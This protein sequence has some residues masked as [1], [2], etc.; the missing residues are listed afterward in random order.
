MKQPIA[1][2]TPKLTV[3]VPVRDRR[4]LIGRALRSI[5]SQKGVEFRI[6]VVDNGSTD[7]TAGEL[8]R[9]R[10]ELSASGTDITVTEEPQAGACRARNAGFA[11]TD[12]PWVMF[13]D[14]DDEMLPGHLARMMDAA[15]DD[16]DI[17]GAPATLLTTG[18]RRIKEL[19]FRPGMR[20]HLMHATFSTQRIAV[21][22]SLLRDAGGWNASLP[23]WNDWELGVRLL[24]RSPRVVIAGTEPLVNVYLQ[25]K[26]LTGTDFSSHPGNW[27]P[28]L[29]EVE[30]LTAGTPWMP[31]VKARRA[32]LAA[33]YRHEGA[34]ELAQA[35]MRR[36]LSGELTR[37]QRRW[38]RLIYHTVR[39]L[40]HGGAFLAL[41]GL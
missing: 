14:S 29:S 38:L 40:G 16:V 32:I 7:G 30:R 5:A 6:I 33:M 20:H 8:E 15:R 12:S 19:P 41:R 23:A 1:S 24:L 37:G 36:A 31:L 34:A 2:R 25:D 26:S 4:H 22:S 3:V 13:F 17:V 10:R 35:M 9:L 39:L 18:G 11:L 21:R 28:S 27:E